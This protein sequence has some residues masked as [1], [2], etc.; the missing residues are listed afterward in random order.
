MKKTIIWLLIALASFLIGAVSVALYRFESETPVIHESV[1]VAEDFDCKNPKSFPGRSRK[2]SELKKLKNGPFP[3]NALNDRWENEDRLLD[4]WYGKHLRA[5]REKSLLDISDKNT[6]TY[7]FLWLRTFHHPIAVTA[8]REGYSFRMV[9]REL[10]GAGGYE[11]G[12]MHRTDNI[13]LSKDQW[14]KLIKLLDDASYWNMPP[15]QRDE[16]GEDGAQWVLEGVSDN[17]YHLVDRWSPTTGEFREACL[18][19]LELSGRTADGLKENL[20]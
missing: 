1:Q 3:E 7:R 13:E 16:S 14:C 19:L 17:R 18:Y 2:I 11:P 8:I 15:H 5:M 10:D 20:Y 6:E 12:K 9:S 4:D